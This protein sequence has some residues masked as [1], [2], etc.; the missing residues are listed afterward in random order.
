M[1][2]FRFFRKAVATVIFAAMTIL[3]SVSAGDLGECPVRFAVLGDRTGGHIPGIFGETVNEVERLRPDFVMNVGDMIEGYTSDSTI[4]S[5]EW[6]EFDSIISGLTMP[7]HYTPGNHDITIDEMLDF[8]KQCAA[9][10]YYSFNQRGLHFV[11]LDNSRQAVDELIPEKQL[12]WLIDDLEKNQDAA[13]TMVFFHKPYW[14]EH[15]VKGKPDSMHAIFKKYGVD[16]VFTGHYH[17]YFSA[18][19]DGI[20]YTSVGSSG[21]ETEM[22][23]TGIEYHFVWVTVDGDGIHIA[24]VTHGAVRPWGEF[25]AEEDNF[26]YTNRGRVITFDKPIMIDP[27]MHPLNSMISMTVSNPN[28]Q[29]GMK[30]TL[31]WDIPHGWTV[32]PA[33]LPVTL[34]PGESETLNFRVM[35]GDKPYPAPTASVMFPYAEDKFAESSRQLG[36]VRQAI[37]KTADKKVKID[38]KLD[39]DIWTEPVTILFAPGGGK[40]TT[41]PAEFYFAHDE[42]NLYFAARCDESKADSI[43]ANVEKR[44]GAVYGEDCVGYFL[45]PNADIIYQIYVNPLGT[46]FDQAIATADGEPVSWDRDWNGNYEIKTDRGND[47]WSVEIKIPLKQFGA[48]IEPGTEFGINFRR[49]QRRLDAASDWETPIQYDPKT[50][51]HLMIE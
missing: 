26:Y 17:T 18:K 48:K 39:E 20:K 10:P 43:I 8:Y 15:I 3:P 1:S 5:Q 47:Y 33:T 27:S 37:C 41:E 23:P 42:K 35:M 6:H 30:D 25:T 16:A 40:M 9:D 19:Y 12:N 45:Y 21:A 22:G 13:Y 24:P 46:V 7:F 44:D 31:A 49:K 14:F 29:Y 38:G 36:L 28:D 51:G 11:I 34:K 32:E 50:L 4:L 2:V